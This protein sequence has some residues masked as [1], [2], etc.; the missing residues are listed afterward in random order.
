[1]TK[2]DHKKVV[3]RNTYLSKKNILEQ[4]YKDP[5]RSDREIAKK[6]DSY[7]QKVW[8]E[9][10]KLERK[11][12]IWGYTAVVDESKLNHV[13]YLI[14]FNAKP[15]SRKLADLIIQ[16]ITKDEAQQQ[17]VRLINVLYLNGGFDWLIM[18]SA[19][20]HATA[21]RYYDSLRVVYAR[22]MLEKPVIVD[23]NFL[24]VR[25]GKINPEIEKLEDFVPL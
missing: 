6:I 24:L 16:R 12:I 21:R 13:V 1:L 4:L 5:T 7:R 8:R 14:L 22:Y 20:D 19:P 23:V 15:M 18:F 2:L 10:K 11:K 3:V 9:R 17:K 25:E